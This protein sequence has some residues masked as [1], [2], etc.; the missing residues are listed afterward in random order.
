MPGIP[1]DKALERISRICSRHEK[2]SYDVIQ[3]LQSWK[4]EE[5]YKDKILRWL[6]ENKFVDDARY[7]R[8]Y[9]RDQHHFRKWGK[10][11]IR[12]ILRQ[13]H[14]PEELINKAMEQLD[15][16][17]YRETLKNELQRKRKTLKPKNRYDLMVRL[18]RFAYSKGYEAELVKEV[19]EEVIK[20][21]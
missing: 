20:E 5:K 16:N 9:A 17:D 1:Y 19:M 7:A 21:K 3:K 12:M 6:Q 11:K 18:Q 10:I 2:C 4:M 14:I 15:K 13:K 8:A